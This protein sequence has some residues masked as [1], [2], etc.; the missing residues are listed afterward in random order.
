MHVGNGF[1]LCI[2]TRNFFLII[3]LIGGRAMSEV[4]LEG[5]MQRES[6]NAIDICRELVKRPSEDPPGN[7]IEVTR[8][9]NEY[10]HK[11]NIDSRIVASRRDK[12][13]VV[14]TI[15]GNSPGRHLVF[16]GHIDTFPVGD[17]AVWSQNPFGG[18]V[19]EGKLYGRGSAD[20]KGGVAA[21]ICA[22]TMLNE[23]K[24]FLPGKISITC[25][26][27]EEVNGPCGSR[28]LLKTFP[29]L[30]GDA[31]INAEPSSI[32]HIRIG[33]KGIIQIKVTL[34]TNGGHGAYAGVRLSAIEEMVGFLGSLLNFRDDFLGVGDVDIQAMMESCRE[35][36]D[37]MLCKGAT[38]EALRPSLN[39]GTIN[40]GIMVNMVAEK[41]EAALDFRLPPGLSEKTIVSW[42]EQKIKKY[43]QIKYEVIKEEA[44]PLTKRNHP[45]V[46]I[47]KQVASEITG[48]MIFENYSLG[49]TE[50]CLWR[51][52]GVPAITYG[53]NHHNM[54]SPDE[55]VLAEELPIVAR[56]H[57]L[58]AW[59]FLTKTDI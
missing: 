39:I 33:E 50:A 21:F 22:A 10:F 8:Y 25:V 20:M 51:S 30:Y 46:N 18:D 13:N 32:E 52:R 53:P 5:I 29:E 2:A 48:K 38:D 6:K 57:A 37:K 40:G 26:S 31:L 45:L 23:I 9:I 27:D 47:A 55:Y 44:A 1:I 12:P 41:C 17:A 35:S 54:G 59:R 14:A 15:E 3:A 58:T 24:E 11:C 49:G 34:R 56:V 16:N 7:T 42:V 19:V 28:Y 43:P 36:Y 4:K